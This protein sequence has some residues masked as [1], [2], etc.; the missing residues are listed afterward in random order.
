MIECSYVFL[1]QLLSVVNRALGEKWM[2]NVL[3]ILVVLMFDKSDGG[4]IPTQK[5][6]HERIFVKLGAVDPR[7]CVR[8][9]EVKLYRH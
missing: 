4:A 9:V 6:V 2:E 7:V 8:M 5:S 3:A 1:D